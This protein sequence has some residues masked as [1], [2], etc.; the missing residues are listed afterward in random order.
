VGQTDRR[1]NGAQPRAVLF[2][3]DD[4]TVAYALYRDDGRGGHHIC[5]FFVTRERRRQGVG[6]QAMEMLADEV[7]R[8]GARV[9]LEVLTANSAARGFYESLGFATYALTLERTSPEARVAAFN[10]LQAT[11]RIAPSGVVPQAGFERVAA[12]GYGT[13]IDLVPHDSEH[14]LHDE[15]QRV[16]TA[17]MAYVHIPVDFHAPAPEALEEFSDAMQ[18]AGEA[19]VRVHCAANWRVTALVS[20]YAERHLDWSVEDSEALIAQVWQP[21]ATWRAFMERMRARAP[22]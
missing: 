4:D 8:R 10:F 12:A 16:E 19:K 21:D 22:S 2:T 3:E 9:V 11:D 13:V 7:L 6:R 18:Q 14:F 5:Q 17:R 1:C 20:L 15:A